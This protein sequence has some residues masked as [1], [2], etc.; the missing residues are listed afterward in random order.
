MELLAFAAEQADL[1]GQFGLIAGTECD[2]QRGQRIIARQGHGPF[3]Q[4]AHP[5][6]FKTG[7]R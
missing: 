2:M 3:D 5:G 1:F 4:G 7:A 6:L